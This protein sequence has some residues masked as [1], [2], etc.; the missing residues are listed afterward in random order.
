M[1]VKKTEGSVAD[2]AEPRVADPSFVVIIL[3]VEVIVATVFEGSSVPTP[4][5]RCEV[6]TPEE[7]EKP[8]GRVEASGLGVG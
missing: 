2:D 4:G 6:E 8:L 7:L 1:D 5:K 3:D